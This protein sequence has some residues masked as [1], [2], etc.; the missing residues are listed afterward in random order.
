MQNLALLK[1]LSN[2]ALAVLVSLCF[3]GLVAGTLFWAAARS[4]EVA[5]TRQRDL[6][7]LIISKAQIGIAHDQES[8]TVW[9][10]AVREVRA[11]NLEWI[12]TNLGQ[13]MHTYFGHDFA[14]VITPDG[15]PI[16]QF[17]AS[18]DEDVS[19]QQ[20]QA[21]YQPLA[22]T[23]R[24]RLATK[25]TEGVNDRVLTIGESDITQINGHPAIVSVKPI[26]SDTGDIEQTP[27][28]QNLHVAI[29]Y[30]DG[31]FPLEVGNE[32]Q[33][34]EMTYEAV[35]ALTDD[36][37][38]IPLEMR[39][40]DVVGYLSWRPFQPGKSVLHATLPSVGVIAALIFIATI[41]LTNAI[42]RR[43]EKLSESR[44]QLNHLAL[45][46]PLT[47]LANRTQFGQTL[48]QCLS[49]APEDQKTSVLFVDL[50]R[51]KAVND[52]FGHPVGDRLLMLVAERMREI[53]PSALI[54]RI[55]GD[56]FNI[57]LHNTDEQT[58]ADVCGRIVKNL[59]E[60]FTIDGRHIS[61]GA[62]VGASSLC[63]AVDPFEL[64]RQAD[65]A[66]Y[67]AKAAGR[68]TYAL[69]G[70]HMDELL[71]TRRAL[72][73]DLRLALQDRTSIEAAFQPV[74]AS[75]TGELTSMEALARW[76][77]KELG[78]IAPDI[79][80]P[81]AE[82]TGLIADIGQI[83]LEDSCRC[84][85]DAPSSVSI[86]VNV[87]AI[88]LAS[89]SFP[90]R[91]L[92]TL[93]RW[94]IDPARLELEITESLAVE[95]KGTVESNIVALRGAGVKFA[96]DDF[97]TGY[98]SFARIRTLKID[99]MKIDKSFLQDMEQSDNKTLV[100]AMI[101][102]AH[103]RG[104]KITAEG[105]ETLTQCQALKALGCDNLQGYL[106]SKPLSRAM[107]LSKIG[108]DTSERLGS[109]GKA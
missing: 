46:D 91:V 76:N 47:G 98:S 8:A 30:L 101:A 74:F 16:Y 14:L 71:R 55:G 67:H 21:A 7:K 36:R 26:V 59:H 39:S 50:D 70:E 4:D 2:A 54:A 109:T 52:T 6:A 93:E 44:R 57:L 28:Q 88:E 5:E 104:M 24:Q 94:E 38:F 45:H 106:L 1:W 81:L 40:G 51:F 32:Y 20:I 27:G 103:A 42:R 41:A 100:S 35:W 66:L 3:G 58:I 9:D 86:A 97:G 69:F 108:S 107:A 95:K 73:H 63:G 43:S 29:R 75:D 49:S 78:P 18:S 87:S 102:M 17:S 80:I 11:G 61:I 99:R 23:L 53:L 96:I 85:A 89:P 34:S 83:I 10:D 15:K 62:S 31:S 25:D 72:E 92:S 90:L 79:F 77:H 84:L 37:V 65:I 105:V 33:F 64:T 68:N 56:E 48:E 60:P 82:E 22:E 13:W 19:P 12:D